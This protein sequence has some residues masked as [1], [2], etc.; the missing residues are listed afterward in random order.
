MRL[1]ALGGQWT[2]AEVQADQLRRLL[3]SELAVDPEPVKR[4][5]S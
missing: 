1:L 2:A 5:A 3:R 4:T